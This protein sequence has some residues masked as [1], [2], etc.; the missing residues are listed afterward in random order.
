MGNSYSISHCKAALIIIISLTWYFLM[1]KK[2]IILAVLLSGYLCLPVYNMP[3]LRVVA[4]YTTSVTDQSVEVKKNIAIA[5][6]RIDGFVLQPG[7]VLSFNDIVGE[8]SAANGFANGNVLY[9]DEVVLEP[10]GGLCQVSS[11]LFNAMLLSGCAIVE[12]HRHYQPVTYVPLGLDATIKYGKKDLRIRNPHDQPLY[13]SAVMNNSS[14]AISIR[15]KNTLK[16]GYEIVTE[17]EEVSLPLDSDD[18]IRPGM[19]VYIYRN[20]MNNGN[21]IESFLMYKDYYPPVRLQ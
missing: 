3:N 5:C 18:N 13:I 1:K 20:K 2:R 8:G 10:G 9:R 7:S 19:S 6:D 14:L 21:I 12:R 17:E 16:Y 11:T 4:N 15:A